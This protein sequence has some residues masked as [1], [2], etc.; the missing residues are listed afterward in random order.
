LWKSQTGVGRELIKQNWL[1]KAGRKREMG[2]EEKRSPYILTIWNFFAF[3]FFGKDP[4][5]S[6]FFDSWGRL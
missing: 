3:L 4:E 6:K 1:P 5:G 2:K